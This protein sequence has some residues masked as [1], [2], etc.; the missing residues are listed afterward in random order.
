MII[1]YNKLYLFYHF[2]YWVSDKSSSNNLTLTYLIKCLDLIVAIKE[3]SYF[4]YN[5]N[6]AANVSD[7]PRF[8][9]TRFIC[10]QVRHGRLMRCSYTLNLPVITQLVIHWDSLRAACS[11]RIKN[12]LTKSLIPIVIQLTISFFSSSIVLIFQH[13]VYYELDDILGRQN[14]YHGHD[15]VLGHR[16]KINIMYY[17]YQREDVIIHIYKKQHFYKQDYLNTWYRI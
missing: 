13:Y 16:I 10:E 4:K 11:S 17:I 5:G 8:E 6:K 2:E 14:L 3:S 12:P 7:S 15:D 9:N 1:S